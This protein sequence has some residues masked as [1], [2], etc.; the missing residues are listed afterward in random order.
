MKERRE[1][2]EGQE[3]LKYADDNRPDPR[4]NLSQKLNR[5]KNDIFL[6]TRIDFVPKAYINTHSLTQ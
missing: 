2:E 4:E 5:R 6:G 3:A 1:I